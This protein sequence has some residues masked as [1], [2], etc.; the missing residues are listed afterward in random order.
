MR[1]SRTATVV[2][3]HI[4]VIPPNP[5]NSQGARTQYKRLRVAAYCR[6]STQQEQQ[7]TSYEAQVSYYTEKISSNPEWILAGIYA[8]DGKSATMIRKRNDFQSMIDDCMAGKIDMVITKSISRFARNTVDSL[9]NIRKLKA[10]NIA[11]FFEKENI[12]TLGDGGEML[13]TILSSQ[14]QEE[15]RNLSENV[16]W[17]YVR[18]F[19]NGV[20]YVNHNKFLGDRKSVV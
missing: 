1:R 15:S 3:K 6:V 14:A 5:E 11:V 16:H 19:E 13:I 2:K 7:E 12:N 18:Q 10:K 4:S 9:T 20:V 8:D 17:G